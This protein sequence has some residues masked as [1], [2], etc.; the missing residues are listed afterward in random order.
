MCAAYLFLENDG[1]ALVKLNT[2]TLNVLICATRRLPWCLD[3][4]LDYGRMF[5]EGT[6]DDELRYPYCPW[7]NAEEEC[8]PAPNLEKGD[9]LTEGQ[10]F[11]L[12]TGYILPRDR[13]P[14]SKLKK[15]FEDQG[16]SPERAECLAW[17]AYFASC[18]DGQLAKEDSDDPEDAEDAMDEEPI[19]D[20]I[21]EEPKKRQE[22]EEREE[23]REENYSACEAELTRQLK[24]AQSALHAAEREKRLLQKKLQKAEEE[25][26][27][28]R[29]ELSRL[30]ETLYTLRM[31]DESLEEAPEKEI[32]FPYQT[33][34]RIA[35]FGGHDTWQK[36]IR[37][38]L[39]GVRFFDRESLPDVNTV[40]SADVVWIQ[41]NAMPHT[42]YYRIINTARK[43][44]IPVRYFGFA[45]AR[46]CAEQLVL[47]ELSAG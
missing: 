45:S 47:D 41:A 5:D 43:E 33:E 14:S 4:A 8:V 22:T 15:W 30:R 7:E 13:V 2:L 6:P 35:A 32:Q 38:L 25:S 18:I 19:K 36:A 29:T 11:F 31:N 20:V 9:L 27:R 28:D 10:L 17:G 34:R 1:D 39:P 44:N 16:L 37:P 26:M 12:A 3:E 42:L 21:G 46:K 23:N 24:A 40:K